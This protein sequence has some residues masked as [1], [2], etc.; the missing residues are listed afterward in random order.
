MDRHA[1]ANHHATSVTNVIRR[2]GRNFGTSWQTTH[3]R[4][5]EKN[6]DR[7]VLEKSALE[8]G[9]KKRRRR[10]TKS[11]QFQIAPSG[12]LHA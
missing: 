6:A 5:D 2:K 8:D 11:E 12:Q 7:M 9:I 10:V 1:S 4:D 3:Q